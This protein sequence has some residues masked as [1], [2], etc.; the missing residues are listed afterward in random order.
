MNMFKDIKE[1]INSLIKSMKTETN[2]GMKIMRTIQG[3]KV[4]FNKEIE[5]LKKIQTEIK[6]EMEALRDKSTSRNRE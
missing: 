4:V 6:L 1:E 5:S 2:R 3:I